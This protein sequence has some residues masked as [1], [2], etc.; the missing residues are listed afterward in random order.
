VPTASGEEAF[1]VTVP[2][3]SLKE[4]ERLLSGRP[5]DEPLSLYS[6]RGQVVVLWA[7]QVLTSRTIDG[8]YPNYRQ[9]LP[10]SFSRRLVLDRR[11]LTAALER[12]AV[13]AEQHNNVVR[14]SSEPL[15]GKVQIGADAQDVG[16]GSESLAATAEGEPIE[17]AFNVR[18]LL[19]GLKA[20]SADQVVLQCNGPTTPAVLAPVGENDT[21]TYLVM[22]VQIRS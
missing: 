5:S 9:L 19:D 22:P 16:S 18:Y 4:L 1:A 2:S 6:E 21:F 13:L 20:I 17:I 11:A 14:L 10:E 7:D 3:R 12:V 8:T 15:L